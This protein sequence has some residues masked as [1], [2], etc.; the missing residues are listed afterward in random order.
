MRMPHT[1]NPVA[2]TCAGDGG[3]EGGC[4]AAGTVGRSREDRMGF[5]SATA[6]GQRE[7]PGDRRRCGLDGTSSPAHTPPDVQPKHEEALRSALRGDSV[8]ERSAWEPAGGAFT[9]TSEGRPK[10][11]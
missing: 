6:S 5:P 2:N 9:V 8:L 7:A 11:L 3:R 4:G 1:P 10:V